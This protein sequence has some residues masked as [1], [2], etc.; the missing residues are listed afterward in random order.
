M[1]GI[2]D[3]KVLTVDTSIIVAALRGQEEKQGLCGKLS[4]KIKDEGIFG[5]RA[6]YFFGGGGC[7]DE[8]EEKIRVLC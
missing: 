8:E 3:G 5:F 4:G 1:K 7:R 6:L 2:R